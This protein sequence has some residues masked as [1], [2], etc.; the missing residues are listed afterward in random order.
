M[1]P[2]ILYT[3]IIDTLNTMRNDNPMAAKERRVVGMAIGVANG[4]WRS[5]AQ[6][7]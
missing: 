6:Q 5:G 7:E 4:E 1:M 3:Y 2:L